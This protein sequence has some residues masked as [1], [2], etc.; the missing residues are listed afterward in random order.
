M[1]SST[2]ER[3]GILS[4]FGEKSNE[5]RIYRRDEKAIRESGY[6]GIRRRL[7]FLSIFG[8]WETP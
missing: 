1:R 4:Y 8:V 5:K 2:D 3:R 6:Q 7:N